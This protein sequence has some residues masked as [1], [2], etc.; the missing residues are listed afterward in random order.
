[1]GRL[2][3]ELKQ[4]KP[5]TPESE[6]F[7][8]L[9]RTTDVMVRR[10][11]DLLKAAGLTFSQYNVLRILRGAGPDGLKCADVAERMVTRDPDV[12]RLL[13]RLESQGLAARQRSAQDRRVVTTRITPA[14][15]ELLARLD[16]PTEALLEQQLGHLSRSQMRTL[17]DL[18]ELARSGA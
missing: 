12:T 1:M 16:R 13:D 14:G 10:E 18:L 3:E 17:S 11:S 7:L 2:R 9:L 15:R 4:N 6:V 8:N 5:F